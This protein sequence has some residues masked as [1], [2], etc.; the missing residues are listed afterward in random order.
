MT[1]TDLAQEFGIDETRTTSYLANSADYGYLLRK[2]TDTERFKRAKHLAKVQL[3]I[4]SLSP[5]D[6]HLMELKEE[7]SR[8]TMELHG[9]KLIG[10]PNDGF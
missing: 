2:D 9:E 3:K 7:R 6:A 4:D 8:L 1:L 10:D 5:E